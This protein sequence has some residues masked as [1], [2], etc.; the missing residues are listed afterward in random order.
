M[1]LVLLCERTFT[2]SNQLIRIPNLRLPGRVIIKYLLQVLLRQSTPQILC[3]HIVQT[4]P[5]VI[6]R[7]K[8]RNLAL[9]VHTM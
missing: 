3:F 7:R 8:Q 9:I 1:I 2:L 5:R 6:R 4:L